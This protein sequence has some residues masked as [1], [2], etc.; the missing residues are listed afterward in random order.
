MENAVGWVAL[1]GAM[2][3]GGRYIV[4]TWAVQRWGIALPYGTLIVN[5][6]GSLLLG[7][8][9]GLIARG[10]GVPDTVRLLLGVGFCGAFTT[11]ST[12]AVETA[13]LVERPS[14]SAALLNIAVNNAL[15]LLAAF[16][17][18]RLTGA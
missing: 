8:V 10:A 18:L 12:F 2:G 16:V 6:A 3:A 5:V 17:G 4:S 13:G 9:A 1:G 7:A 15:C 11:F 14:L